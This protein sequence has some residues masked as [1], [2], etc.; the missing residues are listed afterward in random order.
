MKAYTAIVE[1]NGRAAAEQWA[2]GLRGVESGIETR[3]SGV[4]SVPG[5]GRTKEEAEKLAMEKSAASPTLSAYMV[6][7]TENGSEK[8]LEL[9]DKIAEAEKDAAEYEQNLNI[10]FMRS[11]WKSVTCPKCKS[12]ISL[13]YGG[14]LKVCP[15]C[16]STEMIAPKYTG[17]L[18]G[19]KRKVAALREK[20]NGLPAGEGSVRRHVVAWCCNE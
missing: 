9:R 3:P 19:K 16:G 15:V 8:A 11:G 1:E 20:L 12:S 5:F 13:E 18:E 17:I 6:G 14:H 4:V 7:Y 2:D 10:G